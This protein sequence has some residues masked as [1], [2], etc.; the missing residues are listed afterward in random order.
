MNLILDNIIFTLQK[1]GG[2]SV[3]WSELIKKLKKVN[4][5]FKYIE[6]NKLIDKNIFRNDLKLNTNDRL[7]ATIYPILHRYLPLNIKMNN[8]SIIFHSSYYRTLSRK[9]R[10]RNNV[11]EI[12]TVH[13]FTYERYSSG[14][15]KWIHVWQKKKS[16]LNADIILCISE[17]TKI[18]LLEFYPKFQEKDIRVI[19][20]GVSDSFYTLKGYEN[21]FENYFLYVG[22]RHEYKNFKFVVNSLS[23]LKDFKLKIVGSKL[24][25]QELKLLE[26]ILPNR[27]EHFI[28]I[29]NDRLNI[30]YNKAFALFY[31]SNYEGFG[32]PVVEAMKA[33]C[34]FIALKKS[35]IPEIASSMD[36]LMN[37]L[38]SE[39][40][41]KVFEIIKNK[42]EELVNCGIEKAKEFSWD[43]CFTE[44]LNIYKEVNN[45][46]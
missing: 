33:G 17:N 40:F 46:L 42:R 26:E 5:T 11:I 6:K 45:K 43:K 3:Y 38:T 1:S 4:Y 39:E 2:I 19:Y 18:D 36:C 28:D 16:I 10:K 13:D 8:Q 35:S 37:N 30:L 12:V 27:W 14:L 24:N 23:L 22:A 20:N 32:I 41:I 9:T 25:K 21:I 15:K 44:V 31:P 7:E 29:D 34:P